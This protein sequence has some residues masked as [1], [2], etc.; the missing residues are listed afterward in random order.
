MRY[1]YS[2]QQ[3]GKDVCVR[4]LCPMKTAVRR[5]C[6]EG[7]DIVTAQDM[8][9][10]L[11]ERPVQGTTAAVFCVDEDSTTLK[12]KKIPNYSSLHNFEFTPAG[13]RMWKAYNFQL[14]LES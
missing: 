6:N 1:D 2:E 9:I 11:K 12:I 5:Y 4:I 3:H 7:H 13:L 8:E 14:E 10:A